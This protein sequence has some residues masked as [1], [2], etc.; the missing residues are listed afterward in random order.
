MM[1]VLARWLLNGEKWCRSEIGAR[2]GVGG[3]MGG[4]VTWL[5]W[6]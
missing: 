4:L 3:D 5:R 6:S 2:V 1:G